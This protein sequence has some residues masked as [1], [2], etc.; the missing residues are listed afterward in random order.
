[1]DECDE[2][3]LKGLYPNIGSQRRQACCSEFST[4]RYCLS[5]TNVRTLVADVAVVA[6]ARGHL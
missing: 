5:G 2:E 6:E 4:K 3:A 1:M